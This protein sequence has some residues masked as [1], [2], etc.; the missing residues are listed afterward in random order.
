MHVHSCALAGCAD[1]PHACTHCEEHI[2]ACPGRACAPDTSLHPCTERTC[3]CTKQRVCLRKGSMCACPCRPCHH[4]LC[5]HMMSPCAEVLVRVHTPA[6]SHVCLLTA[7]V[8]TCPRP[9]NTSVCLHGVSETTLSFITLLPCVPFG[10][11]CVV[12]KGRRAAP[13]AGKVL[14]EDAPS[15]IGTCICRW[16]V[17]TILFALGWAPAANDVAVLTKPWGEVEDHS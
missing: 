5:T 17:C 10:N 3:A 12:R 11:D 2:R 7:R 4:R 15:S 13:A 6:G 1:V 16:A 8:C 14:P 9:P